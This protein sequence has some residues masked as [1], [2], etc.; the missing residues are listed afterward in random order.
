VQKKGFALT[1]ASVRLLNLKV[2]AA[3]HDAG[4][5]AVSVPPGA[6]L[7]CEGGKIG[8][9]NAK[10]FSDYLGAGFV[11]VTF[12]DA[13]LDEK[14]GFCI[15]SG[16]LLVEA[17][18]RAFKP[19]KVIFAADVDGIFDRDPRDPGAK[20]LKEIKRGEAAPEV[21][22]AAECADVTGGM[23]GKIKSIKAIAGGGVPVIVI[24][25]KKRGRL[26]SALVGGK[27]TGTCIIP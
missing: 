7:R 23:R 18:A 17:L 9:F 21:G 26:L 1:Q 3:L 12:G 8:G 6:I 24:N 16:D 20:L 5:N 22:A 13:V 27:F 19:E 4:V 14:N 25:G 11:P 15:C 10:K 2:I